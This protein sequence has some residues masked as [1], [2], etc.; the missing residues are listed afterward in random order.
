MEKPKHTVVA[1]IP[2][3][4]RIVVANPS[5]RSINDQ[6]GKRRIPLTLPRVYWLERPEV[7]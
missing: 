6:A 4:T 1:G 7:K 3:T 5:D 2:A